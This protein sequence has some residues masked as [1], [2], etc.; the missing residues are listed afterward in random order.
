MPRPTR[1][2]IYDA[3][4]RKMVQ[5]ALEEQEQRFIRDHASDSDEQLI[6]YIKEQAAVLC[7]TPRYK[8]I[9]G[10]QLI[11]QRFGSWEA[12]LRKANLRICT[13]CSFN[14]LPRIQQEVERQ[15]AIYR[16][17]KAEKKE[18]SSQR[19]MEQELRSGK[20]QQEVPTQWKEE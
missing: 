15:K 9:I 7:Y 20:K 1:N 19:R 2:E 13:N 10:W 8:E 5:Q 6:N 14:K 3:V 11:E 18:R 12:A 16:Q 17:K 4:I